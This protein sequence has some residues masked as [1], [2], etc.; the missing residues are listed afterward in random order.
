MAGVKSHRKV[1][2]TMNA[3]NLGAE[4]SFTTRVPLDSAINIVQ[5]SECNS[6]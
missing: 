2:I 6:G 1:S 3:D 4:A 5:S